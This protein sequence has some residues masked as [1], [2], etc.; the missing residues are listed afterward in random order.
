MANGSAGKNIGKKSQNMPKTG[1]KSV[2]G[3]QIIYFSLVETSDERYLRGT[4][5]LS[6][7]SRTS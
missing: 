4:Y 1:W 7:R 2:S 6:Y 3:I 5:A